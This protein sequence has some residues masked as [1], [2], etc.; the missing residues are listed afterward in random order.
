[1][2]F[3]DRFS[4]GNAW[5]VTKGL[6]IQDEGDTPLLQ[7]NVPELESS[8]APNKIGNR[9]CPIQFFVDGV[10]RDLNDGSGQDDKVKVVYDDN[11]IEIQYVESEMRVIINF[12]FANGCFFNACVY[13]P[14]TDPTIGLLGSANKDVWDD[15]TT[16]DGELLPIPK[17]LTDRMRHQGYEYCTQNWCIR[18]EFDSMFKYAEDGVDFED[19]MHCDLPF[20]NTLETYLV[21]VDQD[22]LDFCGEELVC[23]LDAQMGGMDT[24]RNTKTARLP[25]QATCNGAGGE[26]DVASCC[27]GL[28]CVEVNGMGKE[29]AIEEPKC[30]GE[31][32]NCANKPCCGDFL[33]SELN[34]GR[35]QCHDVPECMPEWHDCSQTGCCGSM[36]CSTRPDGKKQ[37]RNLPRCMPEW[38]DCSLGVD[39]CGG[40]TCVEDKRNGRKQCL[41][42]PTC[43]DKE[44]RDCS[45]SPCCDGL[46]CVVADDGRN[47]C[48]KLP[49]CMREWQNCQYKGCCQDGA[50]PLKKVNFVDSRG[51][52][53][54]QCQAACA[55][56]WGECSDKKPCCDD[57]TTCK[58]KSN[59]IGQCRPSS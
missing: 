28:K 17:A 4:D 15:W 36:T 6:V 43:H 47:V 11:G 46:T 35:Q 54:S 20:G 18:E 34:D 38:Q 3:A 24:A 41:N 55:K 31:W 23:L 30:V 2:H 53:T 22:A 45:D 1:M 57:N 5:S 58:N 33:C 13:L 26:C 52:A 51:R 12:A 10:Q 32:G 50:Y 42:V 21:D 48:R 14:D 39:C 29:C 27:A 44:W 49:E 9:G 8:L 37:C 40:L 19:I 56:K 59:G 16:G 7:F 25:V